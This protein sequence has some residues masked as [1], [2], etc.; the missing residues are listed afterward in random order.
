MRLPEKGAVRWRAVDFKPPRWLRN[1]HLQSILGAGA[2]GRLALGKP[3]RA[4]EREAR[5]E[6]L[7]VDGGVRLQGFHNVQRSLPERRGLVVLLHGWEGSAQSNYIV[8]AATSLLRAGY[9]VY[10]LN[11]RDHGDSHAL[12][13]EPFHSCRLDE[14]VSAVARLCA[15]PGPGLHA[16]AG[17]SLGGNFALRVARAASARGIA[18]DCAL[19]VCPVIDPAAGLRQLE[20]E[21]MYHAYFMYKWRGSLRR[22]QTLFPAQRLITDEDLEL[23]MRELTRALVVRH[24]DFSSL[25]AYLAGYSVAG[26]RLSDLAVPTAILAAADDPVIPIADFLALSCPRAPNSTSRRMAGIARS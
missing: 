5:A 2:L 26:G 16:V 7:E 6:V 8:A 13:A 17:F 1:P 24:T 19:A 21:P 9:D 4:L 20:R 15:R 22:K 12:N 18:L 3:A 10:R 11:F 23:N 25:D 14:V